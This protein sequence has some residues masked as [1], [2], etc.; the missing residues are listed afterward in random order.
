MPAVS[1]LLFLLGIAL[2]LPGW[3]LLRSFGPGLR[4]G[5]LLSATPQVTIAEALELARRGE[6]DYVRVTGRID[7]SDPFPDEFGRP[8]VLRRERVEVRDQDRWRAVGEARRQVAFVLRDRLDE[9]EVDAA[10]LDE[11][12]VVIPRESAGRAGEIPDRLEGLV[13]PA[14]PVRFR[15]DQVSAV[16][17][18]FAVGVPVLAKDGS[19][20]LGPGRGRP[21]ILT[22]LEIDE[23]MRVLARGRRQRATL[24]AGL[25]VIGL[26]CIALALL[27]AVAPLIAPATVLGASPTP[28]A[29]PV[30]DTRS[31]GEG[32]GLVGQPFVIALGVV[33]L[34]LVA[35]GLAIAY[36]RLTAPRA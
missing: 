31:S 30:G 1:A 32:P 28:S 17:H 6:G 36:A 7:A 8:L 34:G 15:V 10:T 29:A 25:L 18:A 11:G 13:D 12:L 2:L 19:V 21:L 22:T 24:A 26:A 35:A 27:F 16:E 4:I 14:L 33:V 23:A 5:R 20:R 9:I 3:L